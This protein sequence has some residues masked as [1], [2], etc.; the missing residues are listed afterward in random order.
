MTNSYD[1]KTTLNKTFS[2]Y[3]INLT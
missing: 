1:T 2:F 3:V